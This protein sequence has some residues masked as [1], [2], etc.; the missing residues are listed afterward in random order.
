MTT[1]LLFA[2]GGYGAGRLSKFGRPISLVIAC[3]A[4][5]LGMAAAGALGQLDPEK[6]DCIINQPAAT[7]A[8]LFR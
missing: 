8:E 5:F 1:I 6:A 4:A 3:F 7:K 2:L